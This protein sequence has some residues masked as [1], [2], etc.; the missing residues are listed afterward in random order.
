MINRLER[1]DVVRVISR[2]FLPL[3]LLVVLD[4]LEDGLDLVL[5]HLRRG[6]MQEHLI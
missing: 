6:Y 1:G 5:L 3:S 4:A 2:Q